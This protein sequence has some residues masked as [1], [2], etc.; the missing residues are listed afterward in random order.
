MHAQSLFAFLQEV[1]PAEYGPQYDSDLQMLFSEFLCRLAQ[2]LPVPDL[3]QVR[4]FVVIFD[5]KKCYL[6]VNKMLI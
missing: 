3:E 1:F 6:Q 5:F 2:L 4:H